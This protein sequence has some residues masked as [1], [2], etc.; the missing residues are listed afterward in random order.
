MKKLLI[1]TPAYDGKVDV[2][3]ALSLAET[4]NQLENKGIPVKYN[5]L[6]DNGLLSL[7]RNELV[8]KFM[9]SDCSHMM[10]IDSD[11]GWNSQTI[12]DMLELDKEFLAAVYPSRNPPYDYKIVP[13]LVDGNRLAMVDNLVLAKYIPAGFMM[14]SRVGMQKI[15]DAHEHLAYSNEGR[16]E[17][18]LFNTELINGSFMGEDFVFCDRASKAGVSILVM[19]DVQLTHGKQTGKLSDLFGK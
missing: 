8:A 17:Y 14:I 3:Y 11:V 1:A 4:K 7:A 6:T 19:P 18:A 13:H 15:I 16:E 12:S 5:I 9:L 2:Q 10:F